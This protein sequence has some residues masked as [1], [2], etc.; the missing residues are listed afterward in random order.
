MKGC[1]YLLDT[2]VVIYLQKGLLAAPLPPGRFALSIITEIEL[3]SFSGLTEAQEDALKGL[4][5]SLSIIPLDGAVKEETIRLRRQHQIKTPDAIIAATA[6]TQ[7]AAF[8][9]NDERLLNLPGLKTH[10]VSLRREASSITDS[11]L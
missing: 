7:G 6:L 11:R 10:T 3:R 2:N 1:D 5:A 4:F 9:T 8:L